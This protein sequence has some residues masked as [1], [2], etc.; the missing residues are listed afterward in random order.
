M[1]NRNN[2][3]PPNKKQPLNLKPRNHGIKK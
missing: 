1:T 2:T 3:K